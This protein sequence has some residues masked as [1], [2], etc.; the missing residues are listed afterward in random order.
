M[1]GKLFSNRSALPGFF[2][3]F[4]IKLFFS[5]IEKRA[6][7]NKWLSLNYEDYCEIRSISIQEK[8]EKK[9]TLAH[10]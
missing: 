2:F 5:L 8:K 10:A 6:S 1:Y 4:Q 9:P 7:F 3:Y